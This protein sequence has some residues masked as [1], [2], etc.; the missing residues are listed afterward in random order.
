MLNNK[1]A[2]NGAAKSKGLVLIGQASEI[3]G[4][5][6]DTVRRWD[7]A[8]VISSSRPDGK[9]RYFSVEE[10]Q[11]VKLERPLIISEAA[12][13]LKVS[14]STLRRLE[15]KGLISPIRNS[16][17]ERL[18][19]R[20]SL[21][22][23]LDSEYFVRQKEVE[24]EVLEPLKPVPTIEESEPQIKQPGVEFAIKRLISEHNISIRKLHGRFGLVA[25]SMAVVIVPVVVLIGVLTAAFLINPELT[26]DK[27]SLNYEKVAQSP[28]T[29]SM[30]KGVATD[31]TKD[32]TQPASTEQPKF[33][34]TAGW[35]DNLRPLVNIALFLVKYADNQKYALATQDLKISDVNAIFQPRSDGGI[36]SLYKLTLDSEKLNVSDNGLVFNL[37]SEFIQGKQ[38]GRN[39]GDLAV[40]P[41]SG[42]QGGEISDGTITTFD[43]ANG[44]ITSDK[45]APGLS[46]NNDVPNTTNGNSSDINSVSAGSGLSGG[47]SSGD[48]TLNIVNGQGINIIGDAVTVDASTTGTTST[49]AS[50]SGLEVSSDG[51]RLIGGCTSG[52]ILKW[53]GSNWIC[54]ADD[55]SGGGGGVADGDKGDIVVS[56]SG[57]VWTVD[58]NSIAL[59]TDSTGDYVASFTA[60]TG[61]TGSASGEG[62]TPTINIVSANGGI[63]ANTDNISLL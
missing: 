3:L 20:Q 25:G 38:P 26:A 30:I 37:N 16:H 36:Q 42:G 11:K 24:E 39:S 54:S 50:V 34:P 22:E 59:G 21:E 56:G 9:N 63:V 60:G 31:K 40:L 51:L 47:G 48:I 2:I 45:L 46:V 58:T 17:G 19:D 35:K 28:S 52:Q 18:Y 62:S 41:V 29:V 7:K 15:R 33:E 1:N 12:Q 5:S 27:L 44:A 32:A 10:L 23:F 14:A 61:L 8:G 4:V 49:T 57:T 13:M 55:N 6:I 43:I 53:N